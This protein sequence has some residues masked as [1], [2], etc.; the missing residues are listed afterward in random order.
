MLI[1]K[2][3]NKKKYIVIGAV[4]LVV[5]SL[6]GVF[7]YNNFKS[8]EKLL[9]SEDKINLDPPT[10]KERQ[11][12]QQRKDDLI[13]NSGTNHSNT[14]EESGTKKTIKPIIT[15]AGQ[16]GKNLEVE[17]GGYVPSLIEN[18]GICTAILTKGTQSIQKTSKA[19]ANATSTDCPVI[20]FSKDE[21]A[22]KGTWSVILMYES[23]A[24]S[25]QSDAKNFEVT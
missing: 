19:T 4:I 23:S 21:V 8:N 24:A 22:N 20:S 18:G 9:S 5:F 12:T 10:E 14:P 17:V 16:Y 7:A 25:G 3:S 11:Q 6:C 15:Y 2:K 13:E 1:K